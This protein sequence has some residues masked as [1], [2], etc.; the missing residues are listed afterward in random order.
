MSKNKMRQV[1]AIIAVALTVSLFSVVPAFAENN[2]TSSRYEGK[3]RYLTATSV[4]TKLMNGKFNNVV[5]AY[6]YDFPDAL[7]GSVLASKVN[8]PILLVGNSVGN[9]KVTLDFVKNN[10]TKDGT[11][12]LLG[13][14]GVVKDEIVNNLKQSGYTNFKRL[15]GLDRYETNALINSELNVPKGT[16]VA[17]ASGLEFADAISISGVAGGKQMPIYLVGN[18]IS[19]DTINKIRAIQPSTIYIAGG[20]GAVNTTIEKALRNVTNNI[21]RFDGI[22]RYET[23]LKIAD[24]FTTS[25]DTALVA[26]AL[27]FPDAL[28][29]SVLATKTNAPVLLVPARGDVSKQKAFID[30]YNIR[31]IIAVG[32]DDVVSNQVV[33]DL[34]GKSTTPPQTNLSPKEIE[35]K[36]PGLGMTYDA[37]NSGYGIRVYKS[38]GTVVA[39]DSNSIELG[40]YKNNTTESNI[41]KSILNMALPTAGNEIH[42][43]AYKPFSNQT[44]QRDGKSIEFFN[45]DCPTIT[46]YY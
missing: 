22:D 38:N 37:E 45:A 42:S 24:Y 3:D 6:G 32:G 7:S 40:L 27:N 30:K 16:P 11:I 34:L 19:Q 28:S 35:A 43:M 17:I 13:G 21:V 46:I 25:T 14:T 20:T 8:A 44:I 29:G 31:H 41:V 26:N 2:K 15:G 39:I 18:N 10:V 12:Y 9:S 5:L 23:S 36:L 4:A 1:I 33:K